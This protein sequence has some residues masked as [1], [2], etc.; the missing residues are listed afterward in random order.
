MFRLTPISPISVV[1]Q[2]T[3]CHYFFV[4]SIRFYQVD[5]IMF[6]DVH[7]TLFTPSLR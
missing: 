5:Y 1:Y 6:F 7:A 3:S 2:V 4:E